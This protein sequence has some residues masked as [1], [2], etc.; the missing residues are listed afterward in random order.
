MPGAL[1]CGGM[2]PLQVSAPHGTGSWQSHPDGWVN[3]SKKPGVLTSPVPPSAHSHVGGPS[4]SRPASAGRHGWVVPPPPAV[5]PPASR[6]DVVFAQA[7]ADAR[8]VS[9]ARRSSMGSFGGERL[10]IVA[11]HERCPGAKTRLARSEA[12]MGSSRW[13]NHELAERSVAG[14]GGAVVGGPAVPER[15]VWGRA[16]R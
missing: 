11:N 15:H 13:P 9:A 5:P 16:L 8:R 10:A 14:V 12:T 3:I 7:D 2:A 1:L 6:S 4:A